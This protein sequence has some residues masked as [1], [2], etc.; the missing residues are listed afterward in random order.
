MRGLE[1]E[2]RELKALLDE[3]DEKI[4]M[5]SR[6]HNFS[7]PSR[8]N[9]SSL[10]PATA[11][12]VKSE[13]A[14]VKEEVIDVDIAAP[15]DPTSLALGPSSTEAFVEAFD[16]ELSDSGKGIPDIRASAF[17]ATSRPASSA[18]ASPRSASKTPPRLLSDQ[19]ISMWNVEAIQ[20]LRKANLASRYFLS[21]VAVIVTHLPS[22]D[23]FANIRAL[24]PR[25]GREPV[26]KQQI[27]HCTAL[28]HF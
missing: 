21:R 7:S 6:I 14:S 5:L 12:Q 22:T 23:I 1:A 11:S 18:A 8:H 24:R 19:Y 10:S 4:D 15:A 27:R 25:S 2:V 16:K 3:K 17:N 26:A 20:L 28:P 9:S 13:L